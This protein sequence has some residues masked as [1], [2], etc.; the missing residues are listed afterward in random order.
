MSDRRVGPLLGLLRQGLALE[1][2]FGTSSLESLLRIAETVEESVYEA[3]S[4]R[5]STGGGLRFVLANPPLR[6][7]A[8]R[9]LAVAVNGAPVPSAEVRFRSPG[10]PTWTE[11][12]SVS[13]QNPLV[14]VPG[15]RVEFEAGATGPPAGQEATVRLELESV[16]IPPLVWFEFRERVGLPDGGR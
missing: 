12:S 4:L 16:A 2:E 13:E 9:R 15:R 8:F 14:L 11:A 7:G 5:R 6:I 10:A 3:G 1:F